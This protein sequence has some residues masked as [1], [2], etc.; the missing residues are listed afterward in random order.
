MNCK[1]CFIIVVFFFFE[2]YSCILVYRY[3]STQLNWDA[4]RDDCLQRGGDLVN[5]S[6]QQQLYNCSFPQNTNFW[7]GTYDEFTPWI[8]IMGC[9]QM[10]TSSIVSQYNSDSPGTCVGNCDMFFGMMD[11]NCFCLP[12][13]YAWETDQST[14]NDSMCNKTCDENMQDS[15]G[16][17]GYITVYKKV[18][19]NLVLDRDDEPNKN[20]I[21]CGC[22]EC[23]NSGWQYYGYSCNQSLPTTCNDKS[24]IEDNRYWNE[25][26]EACW[27]D[28][29]SFLLAGT[30]NDLECVNTTSRAPFWIGL[31]RRKRTKVVKEEESSVSTA[32]CFHGML[33]AG[34]LKIDS[35]LNCTAQLPFVCELDTEDVMSSDCYVYPPGHTTAISTEPL[36][37]EEATTQPKSSDSTTPAR[38][39]LPPKKLVDNN[40]DI[41]AGATVGIVFAV[42]LP[43]L[44]VIGTIICHVACGQRPPDRKPEDKVELRNKEEYYMRPTSDEMSEVNMRYSL[45]EQEPDNKDS[46]SGVA[47]NDTA[48]IS[49]EKSRDGHVSTFITIPKVQTTNGSDMNMLVNDNNVVTKL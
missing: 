30:I 35:N 37:T 24:E 46:D 34:V 45:F 8:Q 19:N 9:S 5:G 16:G 25:G 43:T 17:N 22:V 23:T 28:Y 47:E 31:Y 36:T 20:S 29:Q 49:Y 6:F 1:L 42:V 3:N 26:K 11:N 41:S 7:V 39:T 44:L 40:D 33:T 4:A 10:N 27:S 2:N 38:G 13:N 32:S 14:V 48:S 18:S 21:M 12:D 15:C